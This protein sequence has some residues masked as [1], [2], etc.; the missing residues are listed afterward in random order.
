MSLN[1]N[2]VFDA[3]HLRQFIGHATGLKPYKVARV[4]LTTESIQLELTGPLPLSLEMR[5]DKIDL[6]VE[7]MSLICGQLS[8]FLSLVERLDLTA[9]DWVT[10]ALSEEEYEYEFNDTVASRFL[11]LFEPFTT[12]RS[13]YVSEGLIPVIALALQQLIGERATEVLP[14]LRDLFIGRP[15]SLELVQEATQ[16]FVTARQ[17]SGHPIVIHHWEGS[18][19]DL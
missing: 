2:F 12:I 13:L 16:P 10:Q 14:N 19:A 11:E 15:E 3:P 6:N 8:P 18:E 17:F 4:A 7:G 5:S 1:L 9:D